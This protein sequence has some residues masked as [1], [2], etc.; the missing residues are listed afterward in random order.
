M[1]AEPSGWD[2][3]LSHVSTQLAGSI[4]PDVMQIYW[5]WLKLFS[6]N[7]EGFY[8][9]NKLSQYIDLSQFTEQG[10]NLVTPGRK[11]NGIPIALIAH[12]MYYNAHVWQQAGLEYT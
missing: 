12:V 5:N 1:K 4:E 11:L 8:D 3:Y 6:K 2:G 9:L 10:K 7:G